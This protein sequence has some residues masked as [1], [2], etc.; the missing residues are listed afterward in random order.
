MF[1]NSFRYITCSNNAN[2]DSLSIVYD[3]QWS[4]SSKIINSALKEHEIPSRQ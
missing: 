3:H 1:L 2:T 4:L